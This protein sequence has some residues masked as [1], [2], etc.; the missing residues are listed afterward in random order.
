MKKQI[1]ILIVPVFAILFSNT[2]CIPKRTSVV[3]VVDSGKLYLH[4][5]TNIDTNEVQEYD[6]PYV[7][8]TGRK[9]SLSKAE[10]YISGIQLTNSNGGV[11]NIAGVIL[12]KKLDPETYYVAKVP[13][14][15]YKS[16][17]FSVGIDVFANQQPD[18]SI[19]VLNDADMW[20]G[21]T[22]QPYGYVFINMQ[23]KIDTTA[24]ATGT[25]AQMQP[26]V[27]KIATTNHYTVV[28]MP[29]HTPA[30]SS[31]KDQAMVVHIN[32]DYSKLFKGIQL[33]NSA[34]LNIVSAGDNGSANAN[35][36]AFNIPTMFSYEE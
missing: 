25:A 6:I 20:L 35:N 3:P 13:V 4:L 27:Y 29:D 19:A 7:T 34:N 31:V 21:T 8:S 17:K 28:S 14:G 15:L 9:V 12:L 36:V 5:H 16:I 2:G 33:S 24:N 30:F 18:T 22:A 1:L 26:F 11:Y 23:G 10:L 32:I